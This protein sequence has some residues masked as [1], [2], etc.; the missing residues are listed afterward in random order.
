[1]ATVLEGIGVFGYLPDFRG[2]LALRLQLFNIFLKRLVDMRHG[3]S[4][5][6]DRSPDFVIHR[7]P[8]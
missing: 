3:F 6:L 5:F 8:Q 7:A 4:D 1:M 2:I